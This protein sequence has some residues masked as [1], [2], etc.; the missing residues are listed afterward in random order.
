MTEPKSSGNEVDGRVAAE[1]LVYHPPDLRAH[2]TVEELT[3]GAGTV[4]SETDSQ[5]PYAD[6]TP[7]VS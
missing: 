3:L 2:G 1:K 7:P 4:P 5:E 6:P